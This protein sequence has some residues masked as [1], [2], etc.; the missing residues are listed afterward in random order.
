MVMDAA[1]FCPYAACNVRFESR[2]PAPIAARKFLFS[3][4]LS[5]LTPNHRS[6]A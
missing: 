2:S 1:F 5:F 4:F 6:S 3:C